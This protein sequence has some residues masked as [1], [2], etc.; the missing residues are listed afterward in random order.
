[1]CCVSIAPERLQGARVE[2]GMRPS[3]KI[4]ASANW[5][6][7]AG[8]HRLTNIPQHFFGVYQVFREGS[9]FT[10]ARIKSSM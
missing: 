6:D 2:V 3:L 10:F 7:S 4:R 1:M 9:A 5:E 8:I